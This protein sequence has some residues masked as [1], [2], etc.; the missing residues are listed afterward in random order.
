MA[1]KKL[2]RFGQII[3]VRP[4]ALNKYVEYHARVWPEVLQTI[5]DC[6]I[7][8]YSIFL[9]DHTL[10]AY[11]EYIGDDYETDMAKMAADPKTQEWWAIMK[12][13]QEPISTRAEGEW[14]A[15]M[16][17]VFHTD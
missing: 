7:R 3:G 10:F 15:K 16:Q 9:K 11:F 6:N 13:I 5:R 12:P 8:N 4:E 1:K 17:E 14:W 2:Q